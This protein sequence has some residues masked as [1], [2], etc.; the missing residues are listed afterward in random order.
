MAT[1]LIVY[2]QEILEKAL[3]LITPWMTTGEAAKEL[4][5]TKE[6]IRRWIRQD[7]LP[8]RMSAGWFRV[9]RED[10]AKLKG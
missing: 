1:E 5:V 8:A 3:S 4:G 2:S 10:V 9:R 6:T 7:K